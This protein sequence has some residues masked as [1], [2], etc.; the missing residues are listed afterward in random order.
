MATEPA[1]SPQRLPIKEKNPKV[2]ELIGAVPAGRTNME[3]TKQKGGGG[4][5][6]G[7]LATTQAQEHHG[8]GPAIK[9]RIK[10][11]VKYP[12]SV[13]VAST[14]LEHIQRIFAK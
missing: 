3:M 5:R 2:E 10:R 4:G 12:V 14:E 7:D 6:G 11:T 13:M 9:G 1:R 8:E